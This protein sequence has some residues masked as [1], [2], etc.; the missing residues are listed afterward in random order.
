MFQIF[1]E[2]SR[3]FSFIIPIYCLRNTVN[4]NVRPFFSVWNCHSRQVFVSYVKA[5]FYTAKIACCVQEWRIYIDQTGDWSTGR[6]RLFLP[7]KVSATERDTS[8]GRHWEMSIQ[9]IDQSVSL[10]K[11]VTFLSPLFCLRRRF[12]QNTS[13]PPDQRPETPHGVMM[14]TTY[15]C[16][17][18]C[19]AHDHSPFCLHQTPSHGYIPA[20]KQPEKKNE[21]SPRNGICYKIKMLVYTYQSSVRIGCNSKT[22][23]LQRAWCLA[24]GQYHVTALDREYGNA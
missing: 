19:S 14:Y 8:T 23:S 16:L 15:I 7:L 1:V 13:I 10:L 6:L 11:S 24:G 20:A 3:S 22:V 18:V 4:N 2:F 9:Q 21:A 5:I 17:K 12:D